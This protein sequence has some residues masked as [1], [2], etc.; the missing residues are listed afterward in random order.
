[1]KIFYCFDLSEKLKRKHKQGDQKEGKRV[2]FQITYSFLELFSKNISDSQKSFFFL[3][4]FFISTW[5][6][7][8]LSQIGTQQLPVV[9]YYLPDESKRK[10]SNSFSVDPDN[11]FLWNFMLT[12]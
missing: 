9:K 10:N 7:G 4:H 3:R 2:I 5:K 6:P 1:M 8:Q 12:S 11:I